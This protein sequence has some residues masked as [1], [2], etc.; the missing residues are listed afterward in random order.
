MVKDTAEPT[1]A[2]GTAARPDV[3]TAKRA[4]E[5]LGEV[6]ARLMSRRIQM[7]DDLNGASGTGTW[8]LDSLIDF[9]GPNAVEDETHARLWRVVVLGNATDDAWGKALT[10]GM[11]L[12]T[13]SATAPT[14][15]LMPYYRQRAAKRWVRH[16]RRAWAA[17][18]QE[19]LAWA[20]FD[21]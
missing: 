16:Q 11:E 1:A 10:L 18:P 3:L 14:A 20:P 7:V 5:K 2:E 4:T 19:V 6:E 15:G 13:D 12:A 17:L 8:R 9:H 21:F